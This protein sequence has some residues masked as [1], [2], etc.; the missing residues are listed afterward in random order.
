MPP[1]LDWRRRAARNVG[2]NDWLLLW[3][4][5]PMKIT[6]IDYPR[7]GTI[8]FHLREPSWWTEAGLSQADLKQT[9]REVQRPLT[10]T[11]ED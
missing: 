5:I 8:T 6:G 4:K 10:A 7:D 2:A 3:N 9:Y 1:D 11:T